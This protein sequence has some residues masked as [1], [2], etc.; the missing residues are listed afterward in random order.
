MKDH[1]NG[2]IIFLLDVNYKMK[3]LVTFGCSNTYGHGLD[4]CLRLDGTPGLFPSSHAWPVFTAQQLNLT[5]DNQG[6]PGASNKRIW[7]N[8][9]HYNWNVTK[10]DADVALIMWSFTTRYAILRKKHERDQQSRIKSDV[11]FN[12]NSNDK[13]Q[14]MYFKR[15]FETYD[16]QQHLLAYVSQ[17]HYFFEERNIP[18]FHIFS[19]HEM[20]SGEFY[21]WL[22]PNMI[23]KHMGFHWSENRI[24]V[25]K[26]GDHNGPKSHKAFGQKVGK[27]LSKKDMRLFR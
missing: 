10:V 1:A 20:Y 21:K 18:N 19:E 27:W 7:H 8:A 2:E 14:K 9:L 3:N 17:L 6:Q 24:D 15:I 22:P 16:S 26:D 13:I 4:D 25:A 5:L 23:W 11:N 12:V